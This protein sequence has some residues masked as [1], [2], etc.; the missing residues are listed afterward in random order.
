MKNHKWNGHNFF[1]GR[2]INPTNIP[3]Y[4][5]PTWISITTP[6]LYLVLFLFG[7][8]SNI[9]NTFSKSNEK[10]IFEQFMFIGFFAPIII[11]IVLNATLYDGWR[12]I[13]F[14]Y[15][16]MCFIM[17]QGIINFLKLLYPKIQNQNYL[18]KA[19]IIFTIFS[20][21]IY[22]IVKLHPNQQVYFNLLAGSDPMQNFEG[23]YWGS[24]NKEGLEWIVE[25]DKRNF[26][27][28]V[29]LNSVPSSKNRHILK[30][31][32]RN[33]LRFIKRKINTPFSEISGD[34]Y[35][36]NF[37][38]DFDGYKEMQKGISFPY[39]ACVHSVKVDDMTIMGVYDLSKKL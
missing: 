35:M 10:K 4:Y 22:Q 24:S 31:E 2:Y 21:P 20:G 27:T 34:Y 39:N 16:F 28:I 32:D 23:D 18:F 30:T 15:P 1:F 9:K 14:V 37:R 29:T 8:F 19:V 5:L 26:I 38:G 17:T 3:W 11:I 12:H 6:I 25:N 13:F 36:T 33:R 7:V